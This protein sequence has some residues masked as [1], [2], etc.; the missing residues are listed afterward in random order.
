MEIRSPFKLDNLKQENALTYADLQ[1][2]VK[3]V[4]LT[5][6]RSWFRSSSTA[7]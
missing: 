5:L 1:A 7:D 4:C 2:P 6:V 3:E